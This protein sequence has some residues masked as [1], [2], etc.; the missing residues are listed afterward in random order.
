MVNLSTTINNE[1]M[2]I[3]SLFF[4]KFSLV[5]LCAVTLF[6]SCKKDDTVCNAPT[7]T[8]ITSLTDRTTL[9]TSVNY[10]DWIMIK[11]TNLLSTTK[12]EFNGV[13]VYDSLR[14]ATDTSITVKIPANLPDPL[15][16]P[17]KVFTACGEATLDFQ[18]KQP[19]PVITSFDPAAG[20]SGTVV[21]ITGNYFKGLTEVRLESTVATVISST[22]TEIKFTVPAGINY[23]YIYVTTPVGT[24]KSAKV[25]GL[26]YTIFDDAM[27]TGWSNTSYSSTYDMNQTTI[28]RRGT[29]AI[30]HKFNVGFGAARFTK[31]APALSTSGYTG[32][33]ISIYGTTGTAG[34]KVRVSIVSGSTYDLLLTEGAWTDYQVPF[35]NLGNPATITAITFQEFSGLASLIYIDDVGL[36]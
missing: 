10:G 14:Y 34:K 29:K 12:V 17:V 7:I 21:T 6:T 26:K 32:V 28:V 2:K 35:T 3:H 16:N 13:A 20:N 1:Y 5:V 30:Q 31:S 19:L 24:V 8:G 27:F 25:F 9:L 36:Y 33:K 11:G 18:V 22:Q 23:G 15:N 4:S